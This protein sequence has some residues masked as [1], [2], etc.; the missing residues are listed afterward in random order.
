M[1]LAG[2]RTARTLRPIRCVVYGPPKV[3]K[4]T[5]AAHARGAIILGSEDGADNLEVAKF[6]APGTWAEVV[7]AVRALLDEQHEYKSLIL[8][9]LDWLEPLLFRHV[10]EQNKKDNIEAFGYGKGQGFALDEW[11]K[12]LALLEKLRDKRSMNIVALAHAHVRTFQ[13][14]E[15]EDYDRW[16]MKFEKKAAGLWSEW[17]D[18]VAFMNFQATIKPKESIATTDGKRLL[19]TSPKPAYHAGS[20]YDIPSPLTVDIDTGWA[21]FA[22]AIKEDFDRKGQAA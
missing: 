8:D 22:A 12:F 19:Y 3:G 2:V 20:R 21:D 6:N 11:R 18:V 1:S 16:E 14:P 10:C 7:Q 17:P 5:F 9:T 4:T 15:G 13:N